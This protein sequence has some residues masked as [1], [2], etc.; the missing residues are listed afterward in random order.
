[1]AVADARS[2]CGRQG[3]ARVPRLPCPSWRRPTPL[4]RLRLGHGCV[5][6]SRRLNHAALMTAHFGRD[7]LVCELGEGVVATV[8]V[9]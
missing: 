9:M 6:F 3:G 7:G 4:G 5:E 2:T 8:G 1:M